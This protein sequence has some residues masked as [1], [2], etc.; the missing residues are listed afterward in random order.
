MVAGNRTQSGQHLFLIARSTGGQPM[1]L[2]HGVIGRVTF[3]II[4]EWWAVIG[5]C[6]LG[7]RGRLK[8]SITW[9]CTRVAP[10]Q[11]VTLGLV[12]VEY[13]R[14]DPRR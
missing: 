14:E 12:H 6:T 1:S 13:P 2:G 7:S 10:G 11:V 5:I 8:A 4:R 3:G 9:P